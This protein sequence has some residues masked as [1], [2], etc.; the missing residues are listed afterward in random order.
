MSCA[1]AAT[2][3]YPVLQVSSSVTN[4]KPGETG[5]ITISLS[6]DGAQPAYSTEITFT[7]LDEPL[8][9]SRACT[10]CMVYSTTRK[11]CLLYNE[12]CYQQMGDVYGDNA[13]DITYEI[14]IP[15][16][17][18]TGYYFAEFLIKYVS[19]NSTAGTEQTNYIYKHEI[20]RIENNETKPDLTV[21]Q[22]VTNP[23][24]INPGQKFNATLS[25]ENSGSFNA[26]NTKVRINYTT[27]STNGKHNN[28][29]IGNLSV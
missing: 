22:A 7:R 13:K 10:N 20:L 27:F 21:N 16:N 17:I 5:Y 2:P 25:I 28:V 11:F 8:S 6:N 4:M 1:L 14:S 29:S 23:E 3:A 26:S 18:S 9:S 19:Y 12:E 15:A 24:V